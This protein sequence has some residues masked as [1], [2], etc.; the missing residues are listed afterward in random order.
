MQSA[1][2]RGNVL[3]FHFQASAASGC[4]A[5][6]KDKEKHP[7][8]SAA[9]GPGIN[10]AH[11]HTHWDWGKHAKIFLTAMLEAAF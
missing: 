8:C 6:E 1:G 10:N 5:E 11:T 9:W 3:C 2:V 7:R 4:V